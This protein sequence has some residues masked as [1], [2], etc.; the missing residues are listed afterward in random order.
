MLLYAKLRGEYVSHNALL[1]YNVRHPTGEEAQGTWYPVEFSY[2]APLIA[3]Q[4]K[5]QIV[6]CGEAFV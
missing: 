3:E 5:G 2:L 6:L 4:G 1:V